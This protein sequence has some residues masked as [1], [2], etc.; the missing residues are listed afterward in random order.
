MAGIIFSVQR[1]EVINIGNHVHT[2]VCLGTFP[3]DSSAYLGTH[4]YVQAQAVCCTQGLSLKGS[5]RSDV[6]G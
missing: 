3:F 2:E 4:S 1:S 5:Q 6:H